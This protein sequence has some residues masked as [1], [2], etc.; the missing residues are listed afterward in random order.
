[1]TFQSVIAAVISGTLIVLPPLQAAA[2][3]TDNQPAGMAA[4]NTILS[5]GTKNKIAGELQK[6]HMS[7]VLPSGQPIELES[8]LKEGAHDFAT[9]TPPDASGTQLAIQFANANYSKDKIHFN[10]R[11]YKFEPGVALESHNALGSTG[12]T[13]SRGESGKSM[14]LKLE[15]AAS[16]LAASS[17]T[18]S[19]IK[20]NKSIAQRVVDLLVPQAEASMYNTLTTIQHVV[21]VGSVIA[22]VVGVVGSVMTLSVNYVIPDGPIGEITDGVSVI[23]MTLAG[24]GLFLMF[25]SLVTGGFDS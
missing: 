8:L 7:L 9:V 16:Y 22:L 17:Q 15:R 2:Q 10:L 18:T 5:A 12:L 20:L 19:N 11:L 23:L 25:A 24:L 21:A 4:V 13:F 6:D 1:M 3:S 14:K